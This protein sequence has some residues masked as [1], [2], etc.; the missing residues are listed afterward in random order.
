MG[1]HAHQARP[2]SPLKAEIQRLARTSCP[3]A[4]ARLLEH[5]EDKDN[6]AVSVKACEMVLHYGIGKPREQA[7]DLADASDAELLAEVK[8]RE[9]A[10][11]PARASD[12]GL[13]LGAPDA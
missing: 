6:P 5:V 4:M 8:R 10:A 9:Q 12:T 3:R 7:F 13:E 11:H 2:A 1:T